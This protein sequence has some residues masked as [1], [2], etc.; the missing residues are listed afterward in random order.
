MIRVV[1]DTNVVVSGLLKP[2]GVSS[3]T[4]QLSLS[5]P[6]FELAASERLLREYDE[7]IRRPVFGFTGDLVDR[8]MDLLRRKCVVVSPELSLVHLVLHTSDSM[9]LECA[10]CAGAHFLVTGNRKHFLGDR[11]GPTRIV[12]PRQFMD[13]ILGG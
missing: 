13:T 2:G 7:V 11:H 4:L 8:F 3:S 10:V 1:L 6:G 9:V 5:D 12:T